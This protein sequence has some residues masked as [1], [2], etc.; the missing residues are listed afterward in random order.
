VVKITLGKLPQQGPYVKDNL[1]SRLNERRR[2]GIY[3][4]P[5]VSPGI[6]PP[7]RIKTRFSGRQNLEWGGKRSATP[8]WIH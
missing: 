6:T 4:A 1:K 8:L 5:G 7:L 2:R 3:A